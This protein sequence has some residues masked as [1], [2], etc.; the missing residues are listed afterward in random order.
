MTNKDDVAFR[1]CLDVFHHRSSGEADGETSQSPVCRS[2]RGDLRP[3][4]LD[5][6]PP[7]FLPDAGR[8]TGSMNE[9]DCHVAHHGASPLPLLAFV[10]RPSLIAPS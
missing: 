8:V 6:E 3:E 5:Q 10:N 2:A 4:M 7:V 1:G 9:D